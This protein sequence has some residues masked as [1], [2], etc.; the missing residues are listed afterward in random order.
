MLVMVCT[1]SNITRTKTPR[2]IFLLK[3]FIAI[4]NVIKKGKVNIFTKLFSG[5]L[6]VYH[7]WQKEKKLNPRHYINKELQN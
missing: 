1:T 2:L 7:Q 5:I 6:G 3:L 4:T